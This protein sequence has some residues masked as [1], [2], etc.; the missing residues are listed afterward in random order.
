MSTRTQTAG[1]SVGRQK[2]WQA[3]DVD[4][5]VEMYAHPR[6]HE[7]RERAWRS[8]YCPFSSMIVSRGPGG[9]SSIGGDDE[10]SQGDMYKLA[11]PVGR[12]FE[13]EEFEEMDVEHKG[14]APAIIASTTAQGCSSSTIRLTSTL[15]AGLDTT[16]VSRHEPFTISLN[17]Y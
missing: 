1:G 9:S 11:E 14:W 2:Q 6:P 16:V 17:A 4:Y 10:H 13:E 12:V 3:N 7:E 8:T 5:I 15:S